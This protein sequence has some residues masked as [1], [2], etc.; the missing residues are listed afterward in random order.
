MKFLKSKTRLIHTTIAENRSMK[1]NTN[2]WKHGFDGIQ[3]YQ[4]ISVEQ[5]VTFLLK[6]INVKNYKFTY[7]KIFSEIKQSQYLERKRSSTKQIFPHHGKWNKWRFFVFHF[8]YN[9]CFKDNL[10]SFEKLSILVQ[11]NFYW[12]YTVS[13]IK[14]WTSFM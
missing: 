9:E 3:S 7:Y 1:V 14:N 13:Y 11:S 5:P 10:R 4:L 6:C 12:K 8:R 2:Y